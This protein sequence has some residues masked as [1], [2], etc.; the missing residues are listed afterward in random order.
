MLGRGTWFYEHPYCTDRYIFVSLSSDKCTYCKSL[1]TKASAGCPECKCESSTLQQ[2]D[3]RSNQLSSSLALN[4][5]RSPSGAW[6]QE[7]VTNGCVCSVRRLL[8]RDGVRA[9]ALVP[10]LHQ[11]AD[12]GVPLGRRHPDRHRLQG[13][14]RHAHPAAHPRHQGEGPGVR[15]YRAGPRSSSSTTSR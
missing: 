12:G 14:H 5:T 6:S 8:E 1:W 10:P 7:Q 11:A 3:S 2:S 15:Q 4:P 13:A 9:E